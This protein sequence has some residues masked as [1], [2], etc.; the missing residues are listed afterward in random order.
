MV[1]GLEFLGRAKAARARV[2]RR[3]RQKAAGWTGSSAWAREYNYWVHLDAGEVVVWDVPVKV[4]PRRRR[5]LQDRWQRCEESAQVRAILARS[6]VRRLIRAMWR[7]SGGSIYMWTLT[8]RDVTS[9]DVAEERFTRFARW[10]RGR[11]IYWVAVRELQERGAWHIHLVVDK[12]EQ[13]AV[14]ERAWQWGFVWLVKVRGSGAACAYVMKYILKGEV[15]VGRC[16]YRVS[17]QVLLWRGRG[18]CE[19]EDLLVLI[20]KAGV[21][22]MWRTGYGAT[23]YVVEDGWALAGLVSFK[24]SLFRGQRGNVVPVVDAVRSG[25]VPVRPRFVQEV[26][27]YAV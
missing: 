9:F 6:R 10:L 4:I 26:L 16:R 1:E 12:F 21:E 7:R 13:H 5:R 8:M 11:G 27:G 20:A 2:L 3:L 25:A 18:F 14:V 19:R 22:R 23:V 24:G 15:P 17:R